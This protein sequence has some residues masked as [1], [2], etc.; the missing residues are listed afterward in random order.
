MAHAVDRE[1]FVDAVLG[2]A[3]APAAQDFPDGYF[4]YNDDYPGDYYEYDPELAKQM[5]TDAGYP[6]GF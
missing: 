1:A 3:G 5:L 4:A 2:G 6:D